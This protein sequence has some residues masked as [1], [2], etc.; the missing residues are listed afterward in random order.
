MLIYENEHFKV[1]SGWIKGWRV[2][3]LPSGI[4]I[5]P[6]YMLTERV[7]LIW[8]S[9]RSGRVYKASPPGRWAENV[10]FDMFGTCALYPNSQTAK[11]F[12]E[13]PMD[14]L[15]DIIALA[16]NNAYL[17]HVFGRKV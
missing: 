16:A 17:H 6:P 11:E 5:D 7:N 13:T 8:P 4:M 3:I 12:L 9:V 14:E 2:E 1:H 15:R 10:L